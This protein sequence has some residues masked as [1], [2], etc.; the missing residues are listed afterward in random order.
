VRLQPASER[1]EPQI[2]AADRVRVQGRVM[3]IYRQLG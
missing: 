2:Y 1:H 3:G